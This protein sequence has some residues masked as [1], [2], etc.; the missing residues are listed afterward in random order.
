MSGLATC[1][2]MLG[3]WM[4]WRCGLVLLASVA[5]MTIIT[6]N[7]VNC[8][9]LSSQDQLHSSPEPRHYW[10]YQKPRPRSSS[11]ASLVGNLLGMFSLHPLPISTQHTQ[12]NHVHKRDRS[13]LELL[14]FLL[15]WIS[16]HWIGLLIE[17]RWVDCAGQ[18]QDQLETPFP[19]VKCAS[20]LSSSQYFSS[21]NCTAK[22]WTVP[23]STL[24][25][26]VLIWLNF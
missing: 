25:R 21:S 15:L 6:L 23:P 13:V 11:L 9:L 19:S 4:S 8:H 1:S 7:S 12:Y 2:I 14:S 26:I 16:C 5:N 3:R 18:Y 17:S 22:P 24:I 10:S 20:D